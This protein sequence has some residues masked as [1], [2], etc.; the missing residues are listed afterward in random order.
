ML[1][2]KKR[3]AQRVWTVRSDT[4]QAFKR[5]RDCPLLEHDCGSTLQQSPTTMTFLLYAV[6]LLS[7]IAVFQSQQSGSLLASSKVKAEQVVPHTNLFT[8]QLICPRPGFASSGFCGTFNLGRIARCLCWAVQ[9]NRLEN[10][11]ATSKPTPVPTVS[12]ESSDPEKSPPP[13]N[14]SSKIRACLNRRRAAVRVC[15]RVFGVVNNSFGKFCKMGY[16]KFGI[17]QDGKFMLSQKILFRELR[18][19]CRRCVRC[20]KLDDL[21]TVFLALLVKLR[22]VL[23]IYS[24]LDFD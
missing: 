24:P 8:R 6:S 4:S 13:K 10:C 1:E 15:S 2:Y 22:S 19:V 16:P 21:S 17:M 3:K 14:N 20:G 11:L 9:K 7:F 18:L 23:E 5:R 12:T